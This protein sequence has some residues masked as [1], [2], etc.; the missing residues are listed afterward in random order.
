[1]E[2]KEKMECSYL[3]DIVACAVIPLMGGGGT[4]RTVGS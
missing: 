1:L 4:L 2:Q 3:L